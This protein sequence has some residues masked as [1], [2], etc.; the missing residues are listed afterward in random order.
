[1]PSTRTNAQKFC[2]DSKPSLPWERGQD[3]RVAESHQKHPPHPYLPP[4]ERPS[5][6]WQ[7][8]E[9]HTK[10]VSDTWTEDQA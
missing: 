3:A 2:K 4:L 9:R 5:R 10:A 6:S 1:M 7:K 8:G